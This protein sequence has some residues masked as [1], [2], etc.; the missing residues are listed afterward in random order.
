M[1]DK[2]VL[3]C[4][5]GSDIVGFSKLVTDTLGELATE[6]IVQVKTDTLATNENEDEDSEDSDICEDFLSDIKSI[7]KDKSKEV[8]IVGSDSI[9]VDYE[10]A[11]A[12]IKYFKS[13]PKTQIKSEKDFLKILDKALS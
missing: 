13:N 10:S 3:D 6:K 12:L 1:I 2:K 8:K 4:V 5:K 9:E 11:Q 7:K